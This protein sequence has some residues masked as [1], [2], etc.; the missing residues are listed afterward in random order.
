MTS[1]LQAGMLGSLVSC[2][3]SGKILVTIND[4]RWGR[5][6]EDFIDKSPL[7]LWCT[8]LSPE[9]FLGNEAVLNSDMFLGQ[10]HPLYILLK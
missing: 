7:G 5:G 8:V 3:S 4:N 6:I 1:V 10:Q 9:R 2:V